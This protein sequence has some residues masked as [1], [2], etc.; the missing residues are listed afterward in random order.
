MIMIMMMMMNN[1]D[2][3]KQ[4]PIGRRQRR[5]GGLRSSPSRCIQTQGH[6]R[7]LDLVRACGF[8][9]ADK[10]PKEKEQARSTVQE[11][12]NVL[13][14]HRKSESESLGDVGLTPGT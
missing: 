13:K 7:N 4:Q 10:M 8:P 14:Q 5:R 3:N 6:E 2:D 1:T 12:L 9:L 11:K